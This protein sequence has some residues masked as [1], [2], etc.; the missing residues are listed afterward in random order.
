MITDFFNALFAAWSEWQNSQKAKEVVARALGNMK[1]S[2]NFGTQEK[3]KNYSHSHTKQPLLQMDDE[4]ELLES[5]TV[6]N[7]TEQLVSQTRKET[8]VFPTNERKKKKNSSFV[9]GKKMAKHKETFVTESK[10]EMEPT[11]LITQ[12]ARKSNDYNVD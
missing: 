11:S 4:D 9:G 2:S 6:K 3:E 8:I 10:Q 1:Y 7:L 5:E 12:Q